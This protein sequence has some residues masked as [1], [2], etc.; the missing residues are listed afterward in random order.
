MDLKITLKVTS[1]YDVEGF[2]ILDGVY[3]QDEFKEVL[4]RIK[5]CDKNSFSITTDVYST[6]TDKITSEIKVAVRIKA[7]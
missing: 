2:G 3:K 7:E 5:E 4:A 1:F 6:Y